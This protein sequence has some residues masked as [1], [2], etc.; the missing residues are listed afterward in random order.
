[1]FIRVV[2][3][4]GSLLDWDQLPDRLRQ[5]VMQRSPRAVSLVVAGGG[6]IV[7]AVR[8]YDQTHALNQEDCHWLC[9]DLMDSTTKL[10]AMLISDWPILQ[11]P[12]ELA[13]WLRLQSND[14]N[15]SGAV[16]IVSPKAFYSRTLH[17]DRLP[18]SWDT[19]SDSIS[20][21]LADLVSANELILLKSTANALDDLVDA[22]FESI[23]PRQTILHIVDLR[24]PKAGNAIFE[25][26]TRLRINEH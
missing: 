8:R 26:Q 24:E 23:R 21:L 4:G 19:T 22:Y 5:F 12:E 11:S 1:M 14:L 13:D 20:G 25:S 15:L 6:E 2:K 7:E 9:V 17:A 3:V 18:V 16:A 10:V